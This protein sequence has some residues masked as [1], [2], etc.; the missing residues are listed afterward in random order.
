M[1][2]FA[3]WSLIPKYVTLMILLLLL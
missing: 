1:I 3:S 2:I